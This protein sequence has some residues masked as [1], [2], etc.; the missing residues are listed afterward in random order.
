MDLRRSEYGFAAYPAGA[1][2][3]PMS[4]PFHIARAGRRAADVHC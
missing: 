4:T 2:D 3:A 1:V